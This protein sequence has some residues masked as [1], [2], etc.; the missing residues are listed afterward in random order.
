MTEVHKPA[1]AHDV[2]GLGD[3]RTTALRIHGATDWW[4]Y[5]VLLAIAAA[6]ILASLG[7]EA[8][9]RNGAPQ[10]AERDGP[11]YVYGASALAGG[12]ATSE[13]HL[14][15]VMRDL[16]VSARA[17]RV[18]VRPGRGA[19]TPSSVGA[20]LLFAP[21]DAAA[22]AGKP[23]HVEV[24]VR[25]LGVTTANAIAV[26]L[27]NGSPATWATAAIPADAGVVAFNLPAM[28]GA[29]PKGLGIWL[30]SDKID[31]NY[32]VEISRIAVTPTR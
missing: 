9:A 14:R 13:G 10:R 30:I 19:P 20:T 7:F 18:G 23:V 28:A 12:V 32:G 15:H 2:P 17:V 3:R 8:F 22:L 21:G 5:P 11:A 16:G 4:F 6:L 26:S 27:Q 29:A 31:Y 24:S 25:R 1:G